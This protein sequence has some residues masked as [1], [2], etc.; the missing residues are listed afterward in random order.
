MSDTPQPTQPDPA[1]PEAP[2]EAPVETPAPSPETPPAGSQFGSLPAGEP[3][4]AADI[5]KP[6]PELDPMHIILAIL[7]SYAGAFEH[8]ASVGMA[9]SGLGRVASD[10]REGIAKIRDRMARGV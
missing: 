1:P 4:P 9:N 2:P 3:I 7:E 8:I 5:G 10:A 6:P